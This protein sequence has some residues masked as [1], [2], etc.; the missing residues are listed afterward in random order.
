[1][2]PQ[3][4]R[5]TDKAIV[6]YLPVGIYWPWAATA[7]LFLN[8]TILP[9]VGVMLVV[10]AG[11]YIFSRRQFE[12]GIHTDGAVERPRTIEKENDGARSLLERLLSLPSGVLPD[13][14][15]AIVEKEIRTFFR[16]PRFRLVFVMG[17]SFSIVVWLP[18]ALRNPNQVSIVRTHFLTSVGMYALVLLG[19]VTFWNAFGFDRSAAQAW[20]AFPVSLSRVLIAKNLAALFFIT[21]ELILV[22]SFATLAPLSHP[23]LRFAEAIV[24]TMVSSVYMIAFGNLVSVRVP[25]A[26]DPE[27][28]T[29]GGS[30]RSMNALTFFLF[31]IALLPVALAYWGG[32]VFES[33]AVFFAL[34]ALAAVVAGQ[35]YWIS[36]E[37]SVKTALA[38]REAILNELGRSDG[39]L[40]LN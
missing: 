31:P 13:P 37:S 28:V 22:L 2:V 24:V 35:V 10:L 29:Q 5:F 26:L 16:T 4:F 3:L 19:Q 25:R 7:S 40:S 14:F 17:F 11:A 20:Y 15:G 18:M 21:L 32:Y 23:P 1:M 8:Q 36:L 38:R 30:S 34:L 12:K 39:P 27:K 6:S 33:E 9:S